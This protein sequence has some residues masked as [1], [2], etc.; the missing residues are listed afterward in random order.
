MLSI[1]FGKLPAATP[2]ESCS[3]IIHVSRIIGRLITESVAVVRRAIAVPEDRGGHGQGQS[4]G[5]SRTVSLSACYQTGG[6]GTDNH[7]RTNAVPGFH[8]RRRQQRGCDHQCYS[9]VF[10]GFVL[11]CQQTCRRNE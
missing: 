9:C 6:G 1:P 10:H 2:P 8:W 7:A 11:P 3:D 5:I 4:E